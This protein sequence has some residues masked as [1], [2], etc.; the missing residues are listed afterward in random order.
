MEW[1]QP[2]VKSWLATIRKANEYKRAEFGNDAEE[3]MRFF[4]GPHDFM[5][6]ADY[7][8]RHGGWGSDDHSLPNPTFRATYNKVAEAVQLFGPFLYHRNPH[9]VVNPAELP[10]L[11]MEAMGDP[12][13]PMVAAQIQQFQQT[14]QRQQTKTGLVSS[15]IEHYLNYTPNELDLRGHARQAID[16][17]I[18]KGMGL[19]W[20]EVYTPP[21]GAPRMVGSFY[22]SVDNLVMDPDMENIL[23]SKYIARRRVLPVH[24]VEA[25]FNLKPETLRGSLESVTRQGQFNDGED[26]SDYRYYR[27]RG[28]T[29]D[30]FTYWEIYSRIGFGHNLRDY[31]NRR[32]HGPL[33]RRLDK[34]G[35]YI[36]LAVS[37]HHQYPLNL[38]EEVCENGSD[39]DIFMRSQWPTPFWADPTN[40]WPFVD[41]AFHRRPRKVW[42]MSHIKPGLGEIRF[43]NWA[44]SFIADKIKNTS[45]D[46]VAVL[47]SAGEEL[48][49]NLLSG[50]DL[51]LLEIDAPNQKISE[52]VQ[53]L[54]H[55]QF[56][57]DIWSTMEAMMGILERRIGLNELMYGESRKQLRSSAEAQIKG[58]QLRIR[59][60]D[61]AEVVEAA[62]TL[63]ARK[64]AIAAY[65]HLE[66][67]DVAPIL[68][69]DRAQIWDAI[70]KQLDIPTVVSEMDYRIEAGSI[71]KPNR[72]RD[73]ENANMAIQNWTPLFTQHYQ[74]T[75][76]P[77][78]INA[79]STWWAKAN[80][81]EPSRFILQPPP[82]K[83]N[84]EEQKLQLEQ[85]KMEAELQMKQ[86]EMQLKAMEQASEQ[87]IDQEAHQ[88][89]LF[90]KE[91]IH[92]QEIEQDQEKHLLELLQMRQEG[93]L[94]IDLAEKQAEVQ[95]KAM[96]A[97][98]KAKPS[99][100]SPKKGE[101]NA[102]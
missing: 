90:Q 67:Q 56:N 26:S 79:L 88:Q 93:E 77:G 47:K 19:L 64:E 42:P 18:I 12:Q 2:I 82:P 39:R 55:P 96:A 54:Q 59:P 30:L 15:L 97:Q 83:P 27:A 43:L 37:D 9:R 38:P 4:D 31:G 91:E 69:N 11:P 63:V 35:K 80:D 22:D 81:M 68:G 58:D 60:D 78:P 33:D 29:C 71:R 14:E 3:C 84:P 1:I 21:T 7:S 62:M 36:F 25:R 34:M 20:P 32:T 13:D 8:M 66:G 24:E 23:Y 94:K 49:T 100:G 10:E 5:Y 51:T 99:N 76:D 98:A 44:L 65:W 40:P 92:D 85:Q 89:E 16:E 87:Q 52:M 101:S 50:R 61:M 95:R 70:V 48:R 57:K 53:F 102:S 17:A 46:F 73:R 74:M 28:D 41:I 86:A 45:R 72:D 75:G 6:G